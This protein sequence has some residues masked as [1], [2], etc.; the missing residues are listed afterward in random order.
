MGIKGCMSITKYFLFVFNLLFFIL[1]GV[2][3]CFGLWILFDRS[4]FASMLGST[5]PTLKIWCYVFSG[6]GILTMLLGFLG[7]LGSLKEIKCLLGFYFAFLLLLFAAQ[8]TIGVLVYT[9]RNNIKTSAG[10]YVEDL[11]KSYGLYSNQTDIEESWDF[12]QEKMKC[13]GWNAPEDWLQNPKISSNSSVSLYPCSCRNITR[14]RSY[15]FSNTSIESSDSRSHFCQASS[16]DNWPVYH[17]GCMN[18]IQTWLQNN[19]ITVVG[20]C[21]GISLLEL[22]VMTLSMCLCRNLDQNYNKLARYS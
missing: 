6:V 18:R 13:C 4:S 1:G 8:I 16:K 5:T 12:A 21:I 19:I 14:D 20:V 10:K 15:A 22:F 9:Q 7:C 2:L 11:I 3:L 17:T